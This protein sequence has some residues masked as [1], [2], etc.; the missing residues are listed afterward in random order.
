MVETLQFAGLP[1]DSALRRMIA[2]IK[3]P[4]EAQKIERVIAAFGTHYMACNPGVIDHLD[5]AEIMA[6]SLVMLNV[7][8]HNDQIRK[9]KKMLEHQYVRQFKGICKEPPGSSPAGGGSACVGTQRGARG[10]PVL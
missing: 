8:A 3:L 2:L 6:F 7:D 4:G 9:D 10:L 1:L 5:T